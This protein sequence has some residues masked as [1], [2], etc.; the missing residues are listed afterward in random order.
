MSSNLPPGVTDADIE[1][2]AYRETL[3][4]AFEK[5]L[6]RQEGGK[7]ERDLQ[8]LDLL[9][10]EPLGTNGKGVIEYAQDWVERAMVWAEEHGYDQGY[11]EGHYS[12]TQDE[13]RR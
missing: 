3:L 13:L 1:R 10:N 8:I 11:K 2:H 9:Y 4:E 6:N 5:H 12:A 7:T